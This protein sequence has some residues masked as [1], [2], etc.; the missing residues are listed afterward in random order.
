MS[1]IPISIVSSLNNYN[2]IVPIVTKDLVE[3]GGRTAMAYHNTGE[4]T[5]KYEATEK[6]WQ[7]LCYRRK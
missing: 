6:F 5:K 1:I 7:G 2:S 3:N 4:K